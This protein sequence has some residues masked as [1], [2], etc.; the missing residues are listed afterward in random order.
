MK[1][2]TIKLVLFLMFSPCNSVAYAYMHLHYAAKTAQN[3]GVL[4]VH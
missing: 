2:C 4:Y 3:N 1:S